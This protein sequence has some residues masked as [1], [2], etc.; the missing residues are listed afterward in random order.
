MKPRSSLVPFGTPGWCFI[1]EEVRKK[2]G[3]PKYLRAE[4]VL[5]VGYQHMY[6]TV[7]KCLTRHNT[8]VHS[9]QVCWDLEAPRGAFLTTAAGKAV[10]FECA[11]LNLEVEP[12]AA[13]K[14]FPAI[15]TLNEVR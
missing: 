15:V 8:I 1:P 11:L 5:L 4:P 2:R 7:F 6:T 3:A 10:S 13:L 14:E 12:N 9:E